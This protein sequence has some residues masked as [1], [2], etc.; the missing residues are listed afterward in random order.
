MRRNLAFALAAIATLAACGAPEEISVVQPPA[1]AAAGNFASEPCTYTAR[2]IDHAAE[3]G[4]L[5]VAENRNDPSSRLIAL[6][7]TRVLALGEDPAEP[8]F[9]MAGGPAATNMYLS[10]VSQYLETHDV[11][12]VGYR[13]F[14]GGAYLSCP[15]VDDAVG[16]GLLSQKAMDLIA[17]G[18][19]RCAERLQ[20]TGVDT[21]GYTV[22]EVVDD[23]EAARQALGY[24]R[25]NIE[26][27]S[28]GTRL[29]LIYGWPYPERVHRSA[30]IGVNPPGGFWWDPEILEAQIRHYGVLCSA[31]DYCA[32]QTDD[33]AALIARVAL[34]M[35]DHWLVFPV[36]GDVVL[37]VTFLGLYETTAAG[38]VF[39]VWIAADRGDASGMALL[40]MAFGFLLPANFAWGDSAAKVLS[41]DYDYLPGHDYVAD[42]RPGATILGTPSSVLGWASAAG[43]PA[44]KIPDMYREIQ[45][46]AVNTL[47]ISGTLDVS[48]PMEN[49][50]D[51]LLPALE[52]GHQ[53]VLAEFAH[54]C[55][56]YFLQREATRHLLTT[57]FDTGVVD[58]S[59]FVPN[60]VSFKTTWGFGRSPSWL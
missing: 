34:N 11:V 15:E 9:W 32:S 53:V 14:D 16:P 7:V 30:M 10:R 41:A 31:D 19:R 27:T 20:Q 59:R 17:D 55:D 49:A 35:P 39:D 4:V 22:L 2:E 47:M 57:Y 43:W 8:I 37:F 5:V 3:C 21:D 60:Q 44:K 28:Y 45:Q 13:G 56:L 58:A 23:M 36:D 24:D 42:I 38:S 50:R 51:D 18:Y 12:L 54:T 25:I 29:A 46:S 26:S 48:T 6:P 1:G 52:N 40:T 33:L